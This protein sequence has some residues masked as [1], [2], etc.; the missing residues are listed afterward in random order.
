MRTGRKGRY[1]TSFLRKRD[2]SHWRISAVLLRSSARYSPSP[3]VLGGQK[4]TIC[5]IPPPPPPARSKHTHF[6]ISLQAVLRVL[7]SF[8][9]APFQQFLPAKKDVSHSCASFPAISP[10]QLAYPARSTQLSMCC[11]FSEI[12]AIFSS[13]IIAATSSASIFTA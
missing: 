13:A 10:P 3:A 12:R 7:W 5:G 8:R 4:N 11:G 2:A 6:P 1:I 9:C